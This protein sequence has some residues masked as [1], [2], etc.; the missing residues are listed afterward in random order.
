M[1]SNMLLLFSG[2]QSDAA[3]EDLAGEPPCRGL[4]K[5]LHSYQWQLQPLRQ[6]PGDEV[7]TDRSGH[8]GQDIRVLAGEVE[9]HQAGYVCAAQAH[10]SD[11]TS[12]CHTSDYWVCFLTGG[13]KT[14]TYFIT[15]TLDFTTNT[16]W[17]LTAYQTRRLPG[18]HSNLTV[19]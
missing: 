12:L 8:R 15:Y 2:K 1:K 9:G 6:I 17:R 14:S 16:S 7:H 10:W 11:W 3:W 19:F 13:R 4:W 5:R 18:Q